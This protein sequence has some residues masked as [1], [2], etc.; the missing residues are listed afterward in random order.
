V[1]RSHRTDDEEFYRPYLLSI[2]SSQ[3]FLV[4]AA[5]WLYFYNV[6][7]PHLGAGMDGLP[8]LAVLRR[9]EYNGP[10]TIALLP[11]IILD[12]ISADLLLLW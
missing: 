5:R 10:D 6:L 3:E 2:H 7:R 9:L 12:P 8:P 1:E 4:M 11:P